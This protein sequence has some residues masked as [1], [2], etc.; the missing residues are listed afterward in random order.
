MILTLIWL[1]FVADFLLQTDSMAIKKSQSVPWLSYHVLIYSLPF[2]WLG[3][4]YW[5]VNAVMHW[6]TDFASSRLTS[7][8]WKQNK[9]HWFFVVIGADQAIHLTCLI[10]TLP[11]SVR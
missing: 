1:H 3:P 8:L 4:R 10:L 7:K 11:L 6:V 9:R 5:L 2:A